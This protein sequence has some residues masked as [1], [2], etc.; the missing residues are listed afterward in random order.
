[1]IVWSYY[2]ID[3]G[4]TRDNAVEAVGDAIPTKFWVLPETAVAMA[5]K[6]INDRFDGTSLFEM[7]DDGTPYMD[8]EPRPQIVWTNSR[9]NE[10]GLFS[11]SFSWGDRH[12]GYGFVVTVYYAEIIG[13][14]W[15]GKRIG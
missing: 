4:G 7:N 5:V 1:M 13:M 12:A 2:S 10:Q 14:T 9:P 11:K 3:F 8:C 15:R 6:E